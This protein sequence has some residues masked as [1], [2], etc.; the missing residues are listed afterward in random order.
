[1]SVSRGDSRCNKRSNPFRQRY[2]R[3]SLGRD[4]H[5][6]AVGIVMKRLIFALSVLFGCDG[7][8]AADGWL[9]ASAGTYASADLAGDGA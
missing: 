9:A 1:M 8:S 3:L 6:Y 7:L 4:W 5:V 2:T